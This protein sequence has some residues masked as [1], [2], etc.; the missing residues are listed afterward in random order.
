M[1]LPFE[2][3]YLNQKY[4]KKL[5]VLLAAICVLSP[6]FSQSQKL[7]YK[8]K[9]G[10]TYQQNAVVE[11]MVKQT[12]MGQVVEISSSNIINMNITV[13]EENA[14]GYKLSASI[15]KMAVTTNIPSM[16]TSIVY[17][18][19]DDAP[20]TANTKGVS[21]I[22]KGLKDT[23]FTMEMTRRG[24]VTTVQG[25]NA[26]VTKMITAANLNDA[27][28]ALLNQTMSQIMT[29]E[30][31]QAQMKQM[32]MTYPDKALKLG[33]TWTQ[34]SKITT[35]MTLDVET[36]YKVQ[37]I[38]EKAIVIVA[39]AVIAAKEQ[40]MEVSGVAAIVNMDGKQEG[41]ITIDPTTGWIVSST[42]KQDV[43]GQIEVQ[44]MSVPMEIKNIVTVTD[45]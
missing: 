40:G 15:K 17:S 41:T 28:S 42:A 8:L 7:E 18:T 13:L 25:I 32:M 20:V 39:E 3:Y 12:V 45:K 35:T 38:S 11:S 19:E 33:E 23:P 2:S 37:S 14:S 10:E 5:I 21:D 29:D 24:E 27:E 43:K 1:I 26:I 22:L 4:M 36:T 30:S 31:Y 6:A 34:Q 16:G 9:K 44:G